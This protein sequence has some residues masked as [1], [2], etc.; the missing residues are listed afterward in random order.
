MSGHLVIDPHN[1][2]KRPDLHDL[3]RADMRNLQLEIRTNTVGTVISFNPALNEAQVRIDPIACR[4]DPRS[5][6]EVP[7]A[8]FLV[9]MPVHHYG[10]GDADPDCYITVPILPGTTGSIHVFD[11]GIQNWLDRIDPSRGY[12]PEHRELHMLHD[13]EFCPGLNTRAFPI[14]VP[15]DLTALVINHSTGIKLGRTATL[16]VARATDP[17]TPS[18]NMNAWAKAVETAINAL[19]PGTF[20]PGVSDFVFFTTTT[21][22]MG[23]IKT[24]STKVKAE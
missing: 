18:V 23:S 20:V 6:R 7:F 14:P 8:P 19:A 5:G 15:V 21:G 17:T 2:P 16:G 22:D 4:I 10:S 11:R 1:V 9:T 13:A 24:A 12:D 3:S